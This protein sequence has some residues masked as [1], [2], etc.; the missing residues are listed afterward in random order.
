MQY[1]ELVNLYIMILGTVALMIM[2]SYLGPDLRKFAH[3]I[4]SDMRRAGRVVL[5]YARPAFH[6]AWFAVLGRML[7]LIR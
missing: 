3:T 6:L 1:I 7:H 2:T 4:T 5:R